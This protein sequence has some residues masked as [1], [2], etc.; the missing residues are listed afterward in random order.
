[1]FSVNSALNPRAK[2]CIQ[3]AFSLLLL[4]VILSSFSLVF[5][6][7]GYLEIAT[8]DYNNAPFKISD[9]LVRLNTGEGFRT[10]YDFENT[11]D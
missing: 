9:Q 8:F 4:L 7:N 5:G 1:M 10:Y 11:G 2:F 6:Q 3:F